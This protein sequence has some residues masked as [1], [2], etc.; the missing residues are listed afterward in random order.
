LPQCKC[1][2]LLVKPPKNATRTTTNISSDLMMTSPIFEAALTPQNYSLLRD[3]DLSCHSDCLQLKKFVSP[4]VILTCAR[5]R[6]QCRY[7]LNRTIQEQLTPA[8]IEVNITNTESQ[9]NTST[10]ISNENMTSENQV[11]N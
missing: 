8:P 1:A 7:D 11:I 2:S 6:C 4:A 5:D 9:I 3:C 10:I